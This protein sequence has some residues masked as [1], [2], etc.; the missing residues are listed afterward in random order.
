MNIT[1]SQLKANDI[2]AFIALLELYE[3]VFEMEDF[4]MPDSYYLKN[5]LNDDHFIVY[6]A[7]LDNTVIGGLTAYTLT[8]YYS[9]SSEIYVYDLAVKGIHQ[10]KG[11]G[12]TLMEALTVYCR[13]HHYPD[14]FIQASAEDE[15]AV[16]FYRSTGGIPEQVV[17]FTY[18]TPAT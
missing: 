1:T 15:H 6:V 4:K 14:F 9:Q 10:R 18:P 5:L 2:A 7:V 12:K 8:S 17:H 13:D 3:E 16:E 11:V